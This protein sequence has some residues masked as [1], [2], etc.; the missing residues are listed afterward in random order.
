MPRPRPTVEKRCP[1]CGV[2]KPVNEFYSGE[3]YDG[4]YHTY[5]ITCSRDMNNKRWDDRGDAMRAQARSYYEKHKDQRRESNNA[6][7]LSYSRKMQEDNPAKFRAKKFFD[8]KRE[9]VSPDVTKEYLEEL[10]RNTSRCQCCG[11]TLCLEYEARTSRGYRSNPNSPSVDRVNNNR[12]YTRYNIA[13]ICW[14][15]NFRKTDL[16]VLDLE[17]MLAY[18][19]ANGEF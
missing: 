14:E 11:K 3:K 12:G 4:G 19:K 13:I 10:F 5:C 18:V 2:T 17:M 16:T 8:V 1:R 15:C 6:R 9:N 7:V